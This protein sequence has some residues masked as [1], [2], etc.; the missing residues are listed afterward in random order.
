M[1]LPSAGASLVLGSLCGPLWAC[2]KDAGDPADSG[3]QADSSEPFC[4]DAAVLTWENFGEGFTRESCQPC[5]ASTSPDRRGAPESVVFD[6]KAQ[7]LA[8][9]ERIL[10]RVTGDSPTMPPSG[11]V[12]TDDRLRVEI[13][14]RC[15]EG[16]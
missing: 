12:S 8:L 2:G 3:V 15:W 4:A 11:G 14:L 9:S 5:H 1:K 6:D 7:A 10:A 13:W 16:R